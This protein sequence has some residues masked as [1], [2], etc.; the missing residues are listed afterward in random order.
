MN[1]PAGHHLRHEA[2][3][4]GVSNAVFNGLI[5]WLLLRSG[6]ALQ[7]GGEHSFAIDIIATALLLPFIVAL[8]VI[9]LQRSKLRKGRL[10]SIDLGPQSPLQRLADRFPYSVFKS[11][12][13]FGL[14]GCL[15]IA[16]LTLA[17]FYLFGIEQVNPL[18]YSLFKGLWAGAM[19]AVLVVPMVMVALR[20]LPSTN[21]E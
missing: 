8:I 13:L 18:N 17:G 3:I 15:L 1:A 14:I 10:Q 12:L 4:G 5:A 6:P 9:P 11:A 2:L 20:P 7:W 16:P 21:G 19:A